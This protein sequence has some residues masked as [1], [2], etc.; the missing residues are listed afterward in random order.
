MRILGVLALLSVLVLGAT[1]CAYSAP[2]IPPVGMLYSNYD[3][4]LTTEYAGQD[5]TAKEGMASSMSILGLV[6]W[7]DCSVETAA[8]AGNLKQ[9]NFADYNYYNVLGIYQKFT[10]KVYGE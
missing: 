8:K 10:V 2:V 5:V 6:A 7:G 3:A 4:P 9:V 1:G